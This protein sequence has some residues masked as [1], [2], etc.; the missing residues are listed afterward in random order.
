MFR[1]FFYSTFLFVYHLSARNKHM[2]SKIRFT[3]GADLWLFCVFALEPV[4]IS[5][6]MYSTRSSI[7]LQFIHSLF[8]GWW[9]KN[10]CTL[11]CGI[12]AIFFG[13]HMFCSVGFCKL[14]TQITKLVFKSQDILVFTLLYSFMCSLLFLHNRFTFIVLILIVATVLVWMGKCDVGEYRRKVLCSQ[15]RSSAL[16]IVLTHTHAQTHKHTCT[17]RMKK[18]PERQMI[19][20]A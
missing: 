15:D 17:P 9:S 12:R 6:G 18:R 13:P 3:Y 10:I 16:R 2:P 4:S 20:Y 11:C 14:R 1:G 19:F 8:G 5:T 7:I